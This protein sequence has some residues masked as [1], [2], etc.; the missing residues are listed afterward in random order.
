MNRGLRL[1]LLGNLILCCLLGLLCFRTG[2]RH[3]TGTPEVVSTPSSSSASAQV[4]PAQVR[5]QPFID[6]SWSQIES[7]DYRTY[8]ANLRRIGC[9]DQ[10]IEDII[11]ADV[12][13]LYCQKRSALHL[14]EV[15]IGGHW[16]TTEEAQVIAAVLGRKTE[17]RTR[18]PELASGTPVLPLALR[19]I[20]PILLQLDAEQ[21]AAV[22]EL[23]TQFVSEIGGTNQDPADPA[24]ANRW[25]KAQPENDRLLRGMIGVNA[26]MR[27]QNE[28]Q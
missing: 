12:H 21:Q 16:S 3:T 8:V 20:T 15:T 11:R 28:T 5:P 24:Y 6:F 27:L 19:D 9:P 18:S 14:D 1:S 4:V 17:P 2:A 22:A 7:P 23:R 10:T 13:A 25:Q 26:F